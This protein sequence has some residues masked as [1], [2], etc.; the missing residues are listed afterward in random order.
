MLVE[1]ISQVVGSINVIPKELLWKILNML[2]S[3]AHMWCRG[4]LATDEA[5]SAIKTISTSSCR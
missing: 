3:F 4:I 5:W 2:E 1:D